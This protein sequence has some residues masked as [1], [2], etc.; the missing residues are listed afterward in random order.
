MQEEK[1]AKTQ[2]L[3]P[4]ELCERFLRPKNP[5]IMMQVNYYQAVT[6]DPP[7]LS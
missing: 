1:G 4:C 3:G 5:P 7:A 2:Q 6:I